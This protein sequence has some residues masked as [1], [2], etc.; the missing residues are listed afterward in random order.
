MGLTTKREEILKNMPKIETKIEKIPG[1]NLI[2]HRIIFTDVRPIEYYN[3]VIQHA[4]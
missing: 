2:V 1:R 4:K 3:K